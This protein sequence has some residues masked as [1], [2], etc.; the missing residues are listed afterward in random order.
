VIHLADFETKEDLE[1]LEVDACLVATGRVPA[2]QNLGL[3]SVGVELDRRNFI[4]VNDNMAVLSAGEVVPY[5]WAIGDAT[6]KMML[7]HAASA[8][9]IIAVE[10]DGSSQNC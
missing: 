6:G 8:Q 2:T 9:G 5:L 1:V 7:A 10:N 4:P 3:E